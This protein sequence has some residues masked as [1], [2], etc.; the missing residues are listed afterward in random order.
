MG[1]VGA[2]AAGGPG[3]QPRFVM[4]DSFGA[5]LIFV[6][7]RFERRHGMRPPTAEVFLSPIHAEFAD[8]RKLGGTVMG[9][10]FQPPRDE[11]SF[12]HFGEDAILVSPSPSREI[13]FAAAPIDTSPLA[14]SARHRWPLAS[15]QR[16]IECG[17]RRQEN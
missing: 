6:S 14:S 3:G 12:R 7:R 15:P 13:S 17:Q 9:S 10:G 8:S 1:S 11:K 16:L 4:V 5:R 2:G